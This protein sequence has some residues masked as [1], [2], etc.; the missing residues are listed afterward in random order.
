V[1]TLLIKPIRPRTP[2]EFV[3][4]IQPVYWDRLFISAMRDLVGAMGRYDGHPGI[5]KVRIATGI[6]GEDN[7]S[8]D[9]LKSAIPGFNNASWLEYCHEIA[10][11]YLSVFRSTQLEFDL[12]RVGWIKARGTYQDKLAADQFVKFLSESRVFFAMNGLD[13]TH[14]V[15][16]RRGDETGAAANLNYIQ[17][18][19][20]MGHSVGLE[21]APLFTQDWQNIKLIAQAFDDIGASRLV[22]FGDVP[23]A[24]SRARDGA[25]P[26][27]QAFTDASS[28]E[29]RRL[30]VSHATELFR[31][32]GIDS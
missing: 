30:I 31:L 7:P 6:V 22:L 32:L 19:K 28:R 2:P 17:S 10:E 23:S 27:N 1:K 12:D 8:F 25:E 11:L 29:V 20:R 5:S 9:G 15:Q 18:Q 3:N 24:I 21:G 13:S 14:V 16:W 4:S 26:W